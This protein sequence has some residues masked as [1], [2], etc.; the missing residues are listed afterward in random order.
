MKGNLYS[1]PKSFFTGDPSPRELLARAENGDANATEEVYKLGRSEK[2]ALT[3]YSEL[4]VKTEAKRRVLFKVLADG[5]GEF[6]NSLINAAKKESGDGFGKVLIGS[7]GTP[8]SF[9]LL[10]I[11]TIIQSSFLNTI[12]LGLLFAF[13]AYSSCALVIEGAKKIQRAK[14]AKGHL[15]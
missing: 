6:R 2:Y 13:M 12:F 11:A 10:G 7:I 9:A 4:Q 8:F 15:L 1:T 14:E 5:P 3:F